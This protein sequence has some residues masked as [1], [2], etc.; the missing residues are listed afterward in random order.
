MAKITWVQP[1]GSARSFNV[2]TGLSVMEGAIT[3]NVTGIIAECGGGCAC[4]TCKVFVDAAWAARVGGPG[5]LEESLIGDIAVPGKHL[6]LSCQIEVTDALDG[7][8]VHVP[9]SQR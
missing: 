7:L 2:E 8:V 9:R 3:N 4:G 5:A 6:R 1:G